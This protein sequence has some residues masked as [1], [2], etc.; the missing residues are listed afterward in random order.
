MRHL[1]IE[2]LIGFVEGR[3]SPQTKRNVEQHIDTCPL[4]FAEAAEWSLLLDS[5]K[6]PGLQ[7]APDYSVRNCFAMYQISKPPSKLHQLFATVLF[8]S[9]RASATAGV[10]GEGDCRQLILRADDV[11]I[12]LRIAGRPRVIV[13]QMLQRKPNHFLVEVPVRLLQA[14]QQIEATITD[15]VGEFRFGT[16]P[17]GS[18]R[19]QADFPSYRLSGDFTIN[20]METK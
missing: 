8:D 15:T 5:M 6:Q 14:D 13:G 17:A 10:R 9:A 4:C 1:S 18:L 11:D 3:L 12:H 7:S 20:E 2:S 16:A 19:F